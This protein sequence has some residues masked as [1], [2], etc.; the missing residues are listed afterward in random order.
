MKVD[1]GPG[2]KEWSLEKGNL[3]PWAKIDLGGKRKSG[4]AR[5]QVCLEML[6]KGPA[7][8]TWSGSQGLILLGFK[9]L[10]K[11]VLADRNL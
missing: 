10:D 1:E 5:N 4:A 6:G 9:D 3:Q 7:G 2:V 8:V 11:K